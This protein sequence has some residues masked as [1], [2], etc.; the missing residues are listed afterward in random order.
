MSMR[1]QLTARRVTALALL[2]VVAVVC[3]QYRPAA[4]EQRP[5]ASAPETAKSAVK[6]PVTTGPL[7]LVAPATSLRALDTNV[8]AVPR[9]PTFPLRLRNTEQPLAELTRNDRAILMA[10]A[11][12]DTG[13]KAQL[14][15]PE[16]LRAHTDTG[17]YVVQ[18]R[19]AINDAFRAQLTAV[20]AE[21]IAYIPNN[22][23]LVRVDAKGAD[24]LAHMPRTR[25]VLPY[26]PYYKLQ[27]TLLPF[28]VQQAPVPLTYP[29]RL[30]FFPGEIEAGRAKVEKLGGLI[31]R[32]DR[33]PFGPQL[34]V[35]PQKDSLVALATMPEVQTIERQGKRV[36]MNDL[37]RTR[38]GISSN[39][40]TA[41]NYRGLTGTNILIG[42]ND[43]GVDTN[44]VGLTNR[45]LVGNDAT[46]FF[47]YPTNDTSGH[48]THVAGILANSGVERPSFTTNF[49]GSYPTN[50]FRG[51]APASTLFSQDYQSLSDAE[52]AERAA[53]TNLLLNLKTNTMIVNNSWGY[54]GSYEYDSSAAIFDA[55][56]RDAIPGIPGSQSML[57][58]FSAGNEGSG[59]DN[60]LGGLANSVHSPSIAKNVIAVGASELLRFITNEVTIVDAFGNTNTIPW[61][62]GTTD[63][64]NEVAAYSGRGNTGIGREG[65]FGRS[66]PD[67]VAPGSMLISARSPS[68]DETNYYSSSVAIVNTYTNV[69]LTAGATS[70]FALYLPNGTTNMTIEVLDNGSPTVAVP[71]I[72]IYT[73]TVSA[74]PSSSAANLYGLTPLN[75]PIDTTG[76]GIWFYD[77]V[78][79]NT[80][81][82][83]VNVR[84]TLLITNNLGNYFQVLSNDLNQ[85]LA[86]YYRFEVGTSMAA[87]VV[88]GLLA[89]MQE[90]FET[91]LGET[92]NSPAL[93][94]AMLINSA[95]TLSLNYG[96]EP[97][98]IINFQG[99]GLV[100][101]SNALP[102][103]MSS[104]V[105]RSSWPLQYFDQSPT[106]ALATGQSHVRNLTVAPI[107]KPYPLRVTL[108]WTDPPGNPAAGI[109]LVN[110]LNLV[111]SNKV[112]GE[113]Y[114]GNDFASGDV[115]TTGSLSS[116]NPPVADFVNN[117]ENVYLPGD[118]SDDY[119]IYVVG[120]RVNVNAVTAHTNGVVQDYALVVSSG[121]LLLTDPFALDQA[122]TLLE[123]YRPTVKYFTSSTNSLPFLA[124]RVGANPPL[125]T[126]TNGT[127]VQWN[128]YV[129]T[130]DSG[131]TNVTFL[132]FL[133]PNLSGDPRINNY[134]D[135]S[136]DVDLYV[137][138]SSDLTNL[139]T[140]VV[141]DCFS[142]SIYLSPNNGGAVSSNRTGTEFVYVSNSPPNQV[143][144]IGVKA[145]DQKGAEY[146]F[147][148]VATQDP[149]FEDNGD[150]SYDINFIPV[151]AVIPDGSPEQPGGVQMF[152]IFPDSL[153]VQRVV[154]TNSLTHDL[155]GDLVGTL[156]HNNVV[157]TLNNHNFFSSTNQGGSITVIYD[158]SDQ[159][160]ITGSINSEGPGSLNSFVGVDTSGIWTF[161]MIDNAPQFV[162]QIDGLTARVY[163]DDDSRYGGSIGPI[164]GLQQGRSAYGAINVPPGVVRVTF[165]VTSTPATVFTGLYI[166]RNGF[167][168]GAFGDYDYG[169]ESNTDFNYVI[170]T[171]D[172]PP[173]VP[174][175]YYVQLLNIGGP[176]ADFTVNYEYEYDFAAAARAATITNSVISLT[177]DAQT[178]T[179]LASVNITDGGLVA[180][181]RVG[182]R[183]EHER[184]S[185]LVLR[186]SNP[187][188][189]VLLSENRGGVVNTNGYGTG[190]NFTELTY[191]HFSE[192]ATNL[193]KFADPGSSNHFAF[194]PMVV[195]YT[196]ATNFLED[197]TA[198]VFSSISSGSSNEFWRVIPTG[199][200]DGQINIH[201]LFYTAP[202]EL[203][204]YYEGSQL[205]AVGPTAANGINQVTLDTATDVDIAA[206]EFTSAG[207]AYVDG[208]YV[209]FFGANLPGGILQRHPYIV[210]QS[211]AGATFKVAL[212]PGGTPVDVTSTGSGSF[213]VLEMNTLGPLVYN[214]TSEEIQ[215]VINPG[216]S[217]DDHTQWDYAVELLDNVGVTR[218]YTQPVTDQ[219][220][221]GV[222][223]FGTNMYLAG[224]TMNNGV[225][226]FY[227]RMGLPMQATTNLPYQTPYETFNWPQGAGGTRFNAVGVS[228]RNNVY[229][230]GDS[231][232]RTVD[233][234]PPDKET[235]G[236]AVHFP[237]TGFFD[238]GDNL[239]NIWDAQV[240]SVANSPV[241]SYYGTEE[242]HGMITAIEG[243]NEYV[244]VTGQGQDSSTHEG[245]M[246]LSK[247]DDTGAEVWVT[248]DTTGTTTLGRGVATLAD[249]IFVAGT[250]HTTGTEAPMV[251]QFDQSG[252]IL[253]SVI[254]P[255]QGEYNAII[256]YE[257]YLYAVGYVYNGTDKDFLIT[258]YDE[259][260]N[261]IW[262][263]SYDHNTGDDTLNGVVAMG[264]RVFGVGSATDSA[265]GLDAALV[266][267]YQ[268][269]GALVT[270][271][272]YTGIS[273]Y[274]GGASG[275]DAYYAVAT[276]GSD[277]Y[278]VG[279]TTRL[280]RTDTDALIMRYHVKDDY[281]PEESLDNFV[282]DVAAGRWYLEVIDT[283][284]N[285]T[286]ATST[287]RILG[288]QL[289][290]YLADTN[291]V[292]T[293]R[294]N[295]GVVTTNTI[296]AGQ[297]NY[298]VVNVP[299]TA[300]VAVND[301]NITATTGTGS[302][303]SVWYDPTTLP[304][305]TDVLLTN[306]TASA[307]K[308]IGSATSPQL[309][310]G[311]RYF[312]AVVNTNTAAAY[313]Y[314]ITVT[315]DSTATTYM[316]SGGAG[317]AG[318]FANTPSTYLSYQFQIPQADNYATFELLDLTGDVEVRLRHGAPA[319]AA[320]YDI[321]ATFTDTNY[322]A[323][324]L[325]PSGSMPSVVGFWYA[326]VRSLDGPETTY[327]VRIRPP[328][329]APILDPIQSLTVLEGNELVIQ[330]FG[331]DNDVPANALSYSFSSN[332]PAGMTIDE[333]TGIIRWVPTEAQGPGS[334]AVTVRV[335][336]DGLP[337]GYAEQS[338]QVTVLEVNSA[339]TLSP[340]TLTASEG[341]LFAPTIQAV[342]TDLPA[343]TLTFT[344]VNGPS[345]MTINSGT[346]QIG[347]TPDESMGGQTVSFTVRVSDGQ[348]SV[349]RVYDV[350]VSES[351]SAPVFA[352]IPTQT[353]NELS[354][355]VLSNLATDPDTPAN[356]LVYRF[357]G[358]VPAGMQIETATGKITWTPTEAQGPGSYDVMVEA[359]DNGVPP[360][361]AQKTITINVLEVNVAPSL[362]AIPTQS[363][364]EEVL[365]TYQM[366]A[367][368][369]DL[370]TNT[371]TY[372]LFSG[373]TGLTVSAAGLIKWTPTEAQG[374]GTYS[375]TV[376]VADSGSPALGATRTFSITVT[377]SNKP[378]VL[379]AIA[380]VSVD[381][382]TSLALQAVASDTDIPAQTLTYRLTG[383]VPAGLTIN[384]ST[385]A[386]SWSPT[387]VQGPAVYPITVEVSDGVA[388]ASRTFNITVNEV[389]LA[390][391]LGVI[392]NVT[393]T[394]GQAIRFVVTGADADIPAQTLT[395]SL[396]SGAPAGATIDG[397]TGAFE[398]VTTEDSPNSNSVTVRVTD[399]GVPPLSATRT[400]SIT[401]NE[402]VTNVVDLVSGQ[403]VTNTT[404]YADSIVADIY[405]LS[406]S[407]QPGKLLFEVFNLTGN[408]DLLIRRG[409][410]PTAAVFDYSSSLAGT[411]S[412]QVVVSTN[413]TLTDLSGDWF[414]T[415]VNRESTNIVYSISGTVP[416]QVSGG[417]ILV[418]AEG[419]TVAPPAINSG[420]GTP[421]FSWTAVQG[422][423]YQ[424]EVTTDLI[425]WTPLTNIVVDGTTAT[426]TDPTPYG[427]SLQRFYRILQVPQ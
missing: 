130:N 240:P 59:G 272:T 115:Y 156:E 17:S 185:D 308:T 151:P 335:T 275:V 300:S 150:G 172:V 238:N 237:T 295:N 385:G 143:Y 349:S 274:D 125:I 51:M 395:Y 36:L 135:P 65:Q 216:N 26:E 292:S 25:A 91:E 200:T 19:G 288:W 373:P 312:L 12:I 99:W 214:G 285:Y 239:G 321:L 379:N 391:T 168:N 337:V 104:S 383:T 108:V 328:N 257:Q 101:I 371:L 213:I 404:R 5:P 423:K 393:V 384:S 210:V 374:P 338:F 375:V 246:F 356:S 298:Y 225:N 157:A 417:A 178:R 372:S 323:I 305:G 233:S 317:S 181:V 6:G 388:T 280:S 364:P 402:V 369:P 184:P 281:L 140:T 401:V 23:L 79:T 86:P 311:Q 263:V 287:P 41:F 265:T 315:F 195:P 267:V 376:L 330:A 254:A 207:H 339:P 270:N 159:G 190:T 358:D 48:G 262:S 268:G 194:V 37:A 96:F 28:A 141:S 161:T 163:A 155:F 55:A 100:N 403:A 76:Y 43:S 414:A 241:F 196:V 105:S 64:S 46:G 346:G 107:A 187:Y 111:V 359:E 392:P 397:S 366:N 363:I 123:D 343:N 201:Y 418:S 283:R 341:V 13:L 84:E 215:I 102:Q 314:S 368:D 124:E 313:E 66:K 167:P 149:P 219:R 188:R 110:D 226:G 367:T 351:N 413:S 119:A 229:A 132:T 164:Y 20:G 399:N 75:V 333:F 387:E 327:T 117:V 131:Y 221:N 251:V 256:S 83:A 33:S 348:V 72:E 138:T 40:N 426:F 203:R 228:L 4:P 85:P 227:G 202:D 342:D 400:F 60:G 303:L 129:I 249:T 261:E 170:S 118:L 81:L 411:N 301:L 197:T 176:T 137:S 120:N 291:A 121:N 209:M 165:T 278:A 290:V 332:P 252:N 416:V 353:V 264:N 235:K 316:V 253:N 422:E 220:L 112:T 158:D 211:V 189:S 179:N 57:F 380:D 345:G 97:K 248:P 347:W 191:T 186:I 133:S 259:S 71:N 365:W 192:D 18:S 146:G 344:L 78:N 273:L 70:S 193:V 106:N 245:R 148:A 82:V 382:Q 113:L 153:T 15:I 175:R 324:T 177:D 88:S 29:L 95:R 362:D 126:T 307:S 370:P 289:Q 354:A 277:L 360:M 223:V 31:L 329:H 320:D 419:I 410:H 89:L 136:A 415:V 212:T 258:K 306:I 386:I 103:M 326:L 171:A 63:S 169:K 425:N 144:Y 10:N 355:F 217:P 128:F 98:G 247:L 406:V 271:G 340:A 302:G 145:E 242:L 21:V 93:Y 94:K 377:D 294:L 336:D 8:P 357:V 199:I 325:E 412:E 69:V 147:L 331:S 334:Y 405:R 73:N 234:V 87:P 350:A 381:E 205:G 49:M 16:H 232:T 44:Y 2:A 304:T 42:I 80:A 378:P 183:L 250:D 92:N 160:D 34:V 409:A 318:N 116:T 142:N 67:V 408:G 3:W 407:G 396:D 134:R 166:K 390:P 279:A 152:G 174:G 39:A 14:D 182:V 319:T 45:V 296:P 266:E 127:N 68:W 255:I 58:V 361:T 236:L 269:D 109:K 61:W 260:L 9:D 208:S 286:A 50:D 139:L 74:T 421:E 114:Y 282:G 230:V 206:D 204:V 297:T 424:V 7:L 198:T 38:V 77:I 394:E 154:V 32:E 243:G 47:Q 231:Y 56:A 293:L 1:N 30:T 276:D 52:L 180:G 24:K 22:A 427:D 352:N 122:P 35:Q 54:Q 90:F 420:S 309:V 224:L 389:N 284:T 299:L 11:L 62:E 27:D 53:R 310:P 162:G 218:T 322:G 222:A 244:Y 398:W 173:L